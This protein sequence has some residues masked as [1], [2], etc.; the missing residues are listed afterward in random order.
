[1]V[2]L[3]ALTLVP[4]TLIGEYVDSKSAGWPFTTLVSGYAFW[5]LWKR[6]NRRAWIGAFVGV[7]ISILAIYLQAFAVRYVRGQPSY[8]LDH[9]PVLAALK[10]NFPQVAEQLR[11][12][13]ITASGDRRVNPQ[14]LLAK[15]QARILPVAFV[16]MKTTSDAAMLQYAKAKIQQSQEVVEA[17]PSDCVSLMLAPPEGLSPAMQAKII[18]ST[19][20]ETLNAIEDAFVKILND[21]DAHRNAPAAIDEKRFNAL[22]AQLDAKL[23]S[24]Y[25]TSAYYFTDDSGKLPSAVRCKA[26]LLLFK[27]ALNLPEK[28]RSFILPIL[29]NPN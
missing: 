7:A 3:Y 4:P 22:I 11:Q 25:G 16:A 5:H 2:A 1:M 18:A 15:L 27:E 13:V 10:K 9:E 26:G 8:I 14:E 29:F 28:D 17:N 6:L 24:T 20:K 23:K 21:A 12:E 19:S